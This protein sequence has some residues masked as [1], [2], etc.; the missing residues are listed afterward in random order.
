M[1]C[2]TVWNNNSW[3]GG[4]GTSEKEVL[5]EITEMAYL[6]DPESDTLDWVALEGMYWICG[7]Y[8]YGYLPKGWYGSC[9]LG[10][11]KPSFFLLPIRQKQL[12]GLAVYDDLANQVRTKRAVQPSDIKIG[13][14]KELAKFA[15]LGFLA[16]MMLLCLIPLIQMLI[17]KDYE[18]HDSNNNVN[19]V[20]VVKETMLVMKV[21]RQRL[22]TEHSE[23]KNL[24]SHEPREHRKL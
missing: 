14:W 15:I 23:Y 3:W 24:L 17:K 8:A 11:I 22:E 10:I 18:Q 6:K 7:K 20:V 13:N 5:S 19:R 2:L 16:L 12:L 4:S 1:I 9:I 21:G